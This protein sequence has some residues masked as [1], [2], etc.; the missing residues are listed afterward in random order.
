MSIENA[1][2]NIDEQQEHAAQQGDID[3]H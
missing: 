2:G 1:Q 3:E